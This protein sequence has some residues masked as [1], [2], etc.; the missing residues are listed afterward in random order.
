MVKVGIFRRWSHA[1]VSCDGQISEDFGA[2][3]LVFVC[4]N[5][6]VPFLVGNAPPVVGCTWT[7]LKKRWFVKLEANVDLKWVM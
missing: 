6:Q 3:C 5:F 7:L 2:P 4:C 1:D